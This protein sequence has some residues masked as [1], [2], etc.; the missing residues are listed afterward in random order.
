MLFEPEGTCLLVTEMG[1][2]LQRLAFADGMFTKLAEASTLPAGTTTKSKAAALR[3]SP[4]GRFV[5]ASNRGFD[6][7]AVFERKT[8]TLVSVTPAGGKSPRDF[9]FLSDGRTVAVTN[10]F[11]PNVVFF[12]FDAGNGT[13][14]PTGE[15]LTMARP[16]CVLPR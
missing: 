3:I 7:I 8:L 12:D 6:S 4:D 9:A 2:G 10:E 11:T 15:V 5:L 16:L 13:L 14:T 1:N